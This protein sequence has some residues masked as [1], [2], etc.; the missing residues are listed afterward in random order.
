MFSNV[1]CGD[2]I[3]RLEFLTVKLAMFNYM[4]Q[5]VHSYT[6]HWHYTAALLIHGWKFSGLLRKFRIFDVLRD[7]FSKTCKSVEISEWGR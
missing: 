5:T 1:L 7:H 3:L 2:V 4:R 6:E